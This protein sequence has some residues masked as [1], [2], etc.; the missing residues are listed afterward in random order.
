MNDT[1]NIIAIICFASI[2]SITVWDFVARMRLKKAQEKATAYTITFHDF[3]RL[4][5]KVNRTDMIGTMVYFMWMNELYHCRE[6]N[7]GGEPMED[8]LETKGELNFYH[9]PTNR[10]V[11]TITKNI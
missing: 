5:V 6:Y 9:I 3:N 2:L 10:L 11:C 4:K 8:R 1:T 7:K